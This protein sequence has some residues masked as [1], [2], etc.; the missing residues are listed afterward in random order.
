MGK[1]QRKRLRES[2]APVRPVITERPYDS[3]EWLGYGVPTYGGKPMEPLRPSREE[4]IRA[5][6]ERHGGEK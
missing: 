3:A 4:Y 6:N 2:K 1:R 5:W